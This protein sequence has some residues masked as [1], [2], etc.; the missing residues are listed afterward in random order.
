M[1]PLEVPVAAAHIRIVVPSA[2]V[3]AAA[4]VTQVVLPAVLP[5]VAAP[6]AAVAVV[7]EASAAA[8]VEAVAEVALS[9]ADAGENKIENL[10]L[11]IEN[12]EEDICFSYDPGSGFARHCPGDL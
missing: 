12:Y 10:E 7:E 3:H 5:A 9:V 1:V 6:S 2:T 8:V 11:R 4:A